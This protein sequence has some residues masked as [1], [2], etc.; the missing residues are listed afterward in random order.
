MPRDEYGDIP[1]RGGTK[2]AT[3]DTILPDHDIHTQGTIRTPTGTRFWLT[4]PRPMS[5]SVEEWEK[6]C[7]EKWDRIFPKKERAS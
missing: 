1:G 6:Q 7:Q 5:I 4:Q 3:V 2:W